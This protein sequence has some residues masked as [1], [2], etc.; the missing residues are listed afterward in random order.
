M[1]Y[2]FFRTPCYDS[3][4][5]D[6]YYATNLIAQIEYD[7]DENNIENF[8]ATQPLPDQCTKFDEGSTFY[9]K[10]CVGDVSSNPGSLRIVNFETTTT[11]P[12]IL[13]NF[14][15]CS[16]NGFRYTE[17]KP[18]NSIVMIDVILNTRYSSSKCDKL[19]E[20]VKTGGGS[21]GNYGMDP[22]G[23]H[24]WVA[25]G[26]RGRFEYFYYED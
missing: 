26:C 1:R 3:C 18:P 12:T 2:Y 19:D 24:M 7:S 22:S 25:N 8:Q 21:L 6:Q 23:L 9:N 11:M 14:F 17:C 20:P 16:S 13:S 15:D 4:I 10:M 5:L